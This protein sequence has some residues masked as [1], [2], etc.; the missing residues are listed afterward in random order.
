MNEEKAK[1]LQRWLQE[2]HG[3]ESTVVEDFNASGGREFSVHIQPYALIDFEVLSLIERHRLRLIVTEDAKR[4]QITGVFAQPD[5]GD[6]W[7]GGRNPLS[8]KE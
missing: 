5:N 1:N 4:R 6:R 7:H 8:R 2:R 3:I